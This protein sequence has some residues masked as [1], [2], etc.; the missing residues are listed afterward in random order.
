MP[1]PLRIDDERVFFGVGADGSS[2]HMIHIANEGQRV[3][4]ELA[5][6][7]R[8]MQV[9]LANPV[10]SA[11]MVIGSTKTGVMAVDVDTG[12]ELWSAEGLESASCILADGK[13]ILLDQNGELALATLSRRGLNIHSQHR[14]TE[15]YSLTSPTL[16]GTTLYVRDESRM[17]ALDLSGD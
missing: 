8:E 16:V 17:M 13:A 11:G 2:G 1:S 9:Y 3:S 6:S 4:A 7:S 10:R 14:I 15:K 5:W 12:E